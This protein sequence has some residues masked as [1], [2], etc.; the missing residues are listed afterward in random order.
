MPSLR[1]RLHFD[2]IV[3]ALLAPGF[4][5]GLPNTQAEPFV[6]NVDVDATLMLT[7][8]ATATWP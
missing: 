2:L 7:L 1:R 8:S 3:F 4:S 6:Y 5:R